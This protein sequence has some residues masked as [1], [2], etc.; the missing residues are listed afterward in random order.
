[1]ICADVHKYSYQAYLG[2]ISLQQNSKHFP[3]KL[4]LEFAGPLGRRVL[5]CCYYECGLPKDRVVGVQDGLA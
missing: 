5:R 4:S 2:R 1:M 3:N